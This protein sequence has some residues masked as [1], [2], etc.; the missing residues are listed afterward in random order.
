MASAKSVLKV[1]LQ[2]V[3]WLLFAVAG[4]AFWVGGRAIHE[5]TKKDR[6]L[7]EMEGIALSVVCAGLGA[8]AQSAAEDIADA[9][10]DFAREC[11]SPQK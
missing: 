1:F 8:F 4:L 10:E 6:T 11:E 5:F 2:G 3:A 9:E 7:A